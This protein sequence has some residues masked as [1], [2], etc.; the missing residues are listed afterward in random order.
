MQPSELLHFQNELLSEL[1]TGS[2]LK[3]LAKKIHSEIK[4]PLIITNPS[5]RILASASFEENLLLDKY[6]Q[7][8]PLGIESYYKISIFEAK[9]E[10]GFVFPILNN[11]VTLGFLVFFLEEDEQDRATSIA[12]IATTVCALEVSRKN[13]MLS[14]ERQYKEAFIFDLL[15]G[16]IDSNE[17]IITRGEIWGWKLYLPHVVIVF[18]LDEYEQYSPDP[19]LVITLSDIIKTEIS[20]LQEAPIIF[21]KKGE[22]TVILTADIIKPTERKAYIELLVKKVLALAEN[23]LR[24]RI[25]RVGSGRTYANANEL[26][27]SYQEAK[28]AM[29]LGRIM[30]IRLKTPFFRDMGVAR[31][32]Y[33]H[34]QQ[35]L[36]EFYK[37]ALGELVRYDAEQN[38]DLVKTLETFLLNRCDLKLA[39][40]AIF[41]HPNTLRYRLKRIEEILEVDL[42]DFDTKLD[43]NIAFKIK[44]LKR[45]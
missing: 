27:R 34:D 37:D 8:S 24:P 20:K 22:V 17:D 36:A 15:Y 41:L 23:M 42:N 6:I 11:H 28:V 21:K 30:N 39:A 7:L 3:G 14:S 16:N 13:Q 44:H 5:Y 29:E 18:E 9:N 4:C 1:S 12:N 19:Q 35:E 10:C 45:N 40:D 43:L 38:T 2:G 32:L 31:I 33:N 26:F 25:I